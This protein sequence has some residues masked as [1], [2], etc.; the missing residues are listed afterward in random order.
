M[1][2]RLNKSVFSWFLVRAQIKVTKLLTNFQ[3]DIEII[4]IIKKKIPIFFRFKDFQKFFKTALSI[5]TTNFLYKEQVT[6][7]NRF[8]LVIYYLPSTLVTKILAFNKIQCRYCCCYKKLQLFKQ[9]IEI[10]LFST[11]KKYIFK[12]Y[13]KEGFIQVVYT[14]RN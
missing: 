13:C 11:L 3:L 14:S 2:N 7:I 9:S 4:K 8:I 10:R 1:Y 12:K 5:R 6:S